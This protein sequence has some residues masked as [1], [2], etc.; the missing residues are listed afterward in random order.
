MG[1]RDSVV[2]VTGAG[3]GMGESHARA[4]VAAGHRVACLDRDEEGARRTAESIG[5][6]A[7]ALVADVRDQASLDAAVA[8]TIETFGRLDG[9]VANAGVSAGGGTPAWVLGEDEWQLVVD[10]NL[11]GVWRSARA[12]IPAMLERGNGGSLLLVSSVAGLS[13]SPEWSAYAAAKHGVIGLMRTLANE[14]AP[15]GIRCNALCPGMVR[16]PMLEQDRVAAG[17][18]PED[19][20]RE[21]AAGHL[22]QR[23]LEPAELSAV[24]EFLFSDASATITGV[25]LPVDLGYLAR[26][27][28]TR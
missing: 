11:S 24:V 27:P 28:G 14:L 6:E 10:V 25:P 21:F 2:L 4:L 1:V 12:V 22:F 19:M 9:L 26:T 3:S 5:A 8:R 20:E 18:G 16:T 15:Y 17:L 13:A 7:I 23:L